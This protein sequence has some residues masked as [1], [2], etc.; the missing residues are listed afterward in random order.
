MINAESIKKSIRI[1]HNNLDDDI[2]NNID[3]CKL[4]LNIA[5]VYW[6][7]ED[8]LIQKACELYVKW[9]YDYLGKGEQFERAFRNLKDALAL[10]GDYNVRPD[11]NSD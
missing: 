2:Q 10:S 1:S 11:D 4:E 5:G 9:Q 3:A 7:D 8:M 6:K